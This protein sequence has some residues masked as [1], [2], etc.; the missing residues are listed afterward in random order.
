MG[1]GDL[2]DRD[3]FFE[4]VRA[5]GSGVSCR[6][7][8]KSYDTKITIAYDSERAGRFGRTTS[9]ELQSILCL[10]RKKIENV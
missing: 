10:A 7:Y 8:G 1:G 2:A 9:C 5:A 4:R 6:R 3:G